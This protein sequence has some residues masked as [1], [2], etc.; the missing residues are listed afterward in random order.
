MSER[1]TNLRQKSFL[2]G[3]VYFDNRRSSA[4]CLI[5]DVSETGAKLV[6]A[7]PVTLPDLLELHIPHKGEV[8]SVRVQR[9]NGEEIGVAFEG[10]ESP[11]LVPG[12]STDLTVRV[13]RLEAE[14]ASLQ[15]KLR[16]FQAE[17]R[18]QGSD[19]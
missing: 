19:I 9:R 10:I 8:H 17:L 1:R 5:R 14:V 11:S 6:F 18:P 3:R 16:E 2:K 15:R 4:D 7:A 12:A 13:Q